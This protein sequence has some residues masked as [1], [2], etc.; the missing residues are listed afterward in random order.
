[1]GTLGTRG[2]Q[3]LSRTKSNKWLSELLKAKNLK[4]RRAL[5]VRM[6]TILG[7]T[8]NAIYQRV[9][10]C[11]ATSS[12]QRLL[13]SSKCN[14]MGTDTTRSLLRTHTRTIQRGSTPMLTLRL[15]PVRLSPSRA[16][17]SSK[18][19]LF[20]PRG[21]RSQPLLNGLVYDLGRMISKQMN[22]Y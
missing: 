12:P 1:M 5:M 6:V 17:L 4:K 11:P 18:R 15:T 13:P 10:S 3:E 8:R 9:C 7:K 16:P 14:P 22:C 20:H 19:P 2:S 21:L